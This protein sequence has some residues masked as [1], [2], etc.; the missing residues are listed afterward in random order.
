M[1]ENEKALAGRGLLSNGRTRPVLQGLREVRNANDLCAVQICDGTGH[2]E[3]PME[4][5]GRQGQA[6]RG[7]LKQAASTEPNQDW[8]G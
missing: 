4:S 6:L 1:P 3:Y 2:L 5:P 7:R 8:Q